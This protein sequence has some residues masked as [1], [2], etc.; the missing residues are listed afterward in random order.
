[1]A[2]NHTKLKK[3]RNT[4][5]DLLRIVAMFFVVVLHCLG[6]GGV[7]NAAQPDSAAYRGAWLMEICA[8]GAV[9]IFALISGY[10][11]FT[12]K[13][14]RTCYA[15]YI[16]LW[17]QVLFYGILVTV[18][19][20]ITGKAPVTR[21]DYG[22]VLLPVT[23]GLYWYFTA[24]TG[25][26]LIMP[27]LN[28]AILNCSVKTLKLAGMVIVAAFS[29]FDTVAGRFM[30]ASGYSF[31]WVTLLYILGA[32]LKKCEIGKKWK[33]Y[34]IAI[35][36]LA[37]YAIT[38][39]YKL[40]G[41]EFTKL[42]VTVTRDCLISYTSPTVLGAAILYVIAFSKLR[43][44]SVLKKII[45]FAAPGS[46]AIY[47][48]NNH[49]L[50]WEYVMKERFAFL[51][52]RGMAVIFFCVIGFALAFVM[53][54]ILVDQVRILLFKLCN[55]KGLATWIENSIRW[56]GDRILCSGDCKTEGNSVCETSRKAD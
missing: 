1:M 23:N 3:P 27:L 11:A 22:M 6:R 44:H 26:F 10:V 30:L 37:L 31:V 29:F 33:V 39:L 12:G 20:Q 17:I 45:G 4:G 15:N 46:F 35:G 36:I 40:Y 28:K 53:V 43:F 41:P 13:E 50:V 49:R 2:E 7:L 51:A 54:S 21:H 8:Y 47:L 14:K 18:L 52:E 34:Q 25:L 9:D 32:I 38:F 55:I 16:Q 24:Y 48:L 56:L 5:I 42:S 19:F